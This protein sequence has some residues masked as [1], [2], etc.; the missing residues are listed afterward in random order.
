M[1]FTLAFNNKAFIVWYGWFLGHFQQLGV[2][3][4]YPPRH[5]HGS[6]GR[7][8]GENDAL[9]IWIEGFIQ[10]NSGFICFHV[11]ICFLIFE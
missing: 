5:L 6:R 3:E 7:E 8:Q 9:R 10:L 2:E 11:A 1:R 4:P